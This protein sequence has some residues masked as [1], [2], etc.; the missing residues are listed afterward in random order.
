MKTAILYWGRPLWDL[1]NSD[2]EYM[3]KLIFNFDMPS[4]TS[5]LNGL[6]ICKADNTVPETFSKKDLLIE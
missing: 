2:G 4:G 1:R 5:G 3:S 6:N